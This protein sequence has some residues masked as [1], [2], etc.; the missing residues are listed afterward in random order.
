[1]PRFV[2]VQCAEPV[3]SL[4]VEYSLTNIRLTRCDKCGRVADHYIEYELLLVLIDVMLHRKPA[5]RH[6]LFNR[7][8]VEALARSTR[9][10]LLGNMVSACLLRVV[11]LRGS[12]YSA[13]LGSLLH[14]LSAVLLD[15][16]VLAA[17]TAMLWCLARDRGDRG[18]RDRDV[19]R[20]DSNRDGGD[21]GAREGKFNPLRTRLYLSLAV[22]EL[23]R[24]A[25]LMLQI[26]DDEPGLLL[27]LGLLALS[28]QLLSLQSLNAA[29]LSRRHWV[30]C[31]AVGVFCRVA[32]KLLLYSRDDAWRLGLLL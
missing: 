21:G 28:L 14:L 17:C 25:A 18:D 16:L 1:M 12:T 29:G 5:V 30:G 2:C 11:V 13:L 10:V 8:S 27:L 26:F 32:L 24:A 3:E 7:M 22:P 15:Q 20:G 31:A 4:Y 23:L 9:W 19:D 6:M